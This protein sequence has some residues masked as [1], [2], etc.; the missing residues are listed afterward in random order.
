[1]NK[2]NLFKDYIDAI[3]IAFCISFFFAGVIIYS[4]DVINNYSN[5]IFHLT[6]GFIFNVLAL[7]GLFVFMK[8]TRHLLEK[9]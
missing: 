6:M 7:Y 9:Q 4:I 5:S 1:M 8:Y 2:G 3:S